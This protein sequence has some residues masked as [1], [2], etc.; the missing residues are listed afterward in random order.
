MSVTIC[1]VRFDGWGGEIPR[2]RRS[3][4]QARAYRIAAKAFRHDGG[5]PDEQGT[6]TAWLKCSR[7]EA[8]GTLRTLA[9][10]ANRPATQTL[11]AASGNTIPGLRLVGATGS[12][13]CMRGE[14]TGV[15]AVSLQFSLATGGS[16]DE[17]PKS[18]VTLE[19]SS[20]L[21]GPWVAAPNIVAVSSAE[22]LGQYAGE[23][24]AYEDAP[25][26]DALLGLW[27]RFVDERNAVRWTGTMV[28]RRMQDRKGSDGRQMPA[29]TVYRMAGPA[30][31]LDQL[32]LTRWYESCDTDGPDQSANVDVADIGWPPGFNLEEATLLGPRLAIPGGQT[33]IVHER[34]K[35]KGL[36]PGLIGGGPGIDPRWSAK[37]ALESIIAHAVAEFGV[38]IELER[39]GVDMLGYYGA[40][41]FP[42]GTSVG[43]MIATII[44]P[45]YGRSYVSRIIDGK[46][47][48]RAIDI[49]VV[50]NQIDL[51]ANRDE[52]LAFTTDADAISV[53]DRMYHVGPNPRYIRT[54]RIY[55]PPNTGWN[56]SEK[57]SFNRS[58]TSGKQTTWDAATN[59]ERDSIALADVWRSF[60]LVNNWKGYN[61]TSTTQKIDYDRALNGSEE[62]GLFSGTTSTYPAAD[63]AWMIDRT[64]PTGLGVNWGAY[65]TIT[66]RCQEEGPLV[67]R[68]PQ[69][70][71]DF[72]IIHDE[73]QISVSDD[74][75]VLTFGANSDDGATVKAWLEGSQDLFATL[76]FIHPLRPRASSIAGNNGFGIAQP[77]SDWPRI[78]MKSWD[79]E[80]WR[81]TWMTEN[82]IIGLSGAGAVVNGNVGR[83]DAGGFLT[84]PRDTGRAVAHVPDPS[85]TWTMDGDDA[86]GPA[87]GDMIANAL[88]PNDDDDETTSNIEMRAPVVRIAR[89]W[90]PDSPSVTWTV[91][92]IVLGLDAPIVMDRAGNGVKAGGKGKYA[93]Q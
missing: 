24:E 61:Y 36:A 44:S 13:K 65:A 28:G 83:V 19:Y 26:D 58:W 77:R 71:S 2:P 70:S 39:Q 35:S 68:K 23:A 59:V 81:Q 66:Q 8:Q 14:A 74:A 91:Q 18:L 89:S 20:A 79:G 43:K 27:V 17:D 76:S 37:D 30:H 29:R 9:A 52:L 25:P 57:S 90:I 82:T 46:V 16:E 5:F 51:S 34:A 48:I 85:L 7:V 87:V 33:C 50:G 31:A 88:V 40:W 41:D 21:A 12:W 63:A 10:Q 64:I 49:A 69:S 62:T 4:A 42:M 55:D 80:R 11:V 15:L 54:V 72:V 67:F 93:G 3:A 56:A 75:P 86:T 78:G 47:K 38:P 92:R 60:R 45:Q 22:G 84:E 32:I 53:V 1:G 73:M 6:V